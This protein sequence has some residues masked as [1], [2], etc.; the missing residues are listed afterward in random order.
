MIRCRCRDG[1]DAACPPASGLEARKCVRRRHCRPLRRAIR[2]QAPLHALVACAA[3]LVSDAMPVSWVHG[4]VRTVGERTEARHAAQRRVHIPSAAQV[5]HHQPRSQPLLPRLHHGGVLAPRLA[6][7]AAEGCEEAGAGAARRRA[8][9]G[10]RV[11]LCLGVES[12]Q[13]KSV[14]SQAALRPLRTAPCLQAHLACHA[15]AL[16]RYVK[17][18]HAHPAAR[19]RRSTGCQRPRPPCG[20]ASVACSRYRWPHSHSVAGPTALQSKP[21]AL[22]QCTNSRCAA[23]SAALAR[24]AAYSSSALAQRR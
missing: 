6:A 14:T 7:A 16:G 15:P 22:R 21:A 4:R 9:L 11:V 20:S 13:S 19:Q 5:V 18:E 10:E 3:S 2:Q 24:N 8:R 12:T 17:R 23:R 1:L